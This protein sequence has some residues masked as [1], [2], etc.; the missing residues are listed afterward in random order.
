MNPNN[1]MNPIN[2]NNEPFELDLGPLPVLQRNNPP[3]YFGEV[4]ELLADAPFQEFQLPCD[5]VMPARC[6]RCYWAQ[7]SGT[8]SIDTPFIQA[9]RAAQLAFE[10]EMELPPPPALSR[11]SARPLL[12]EEWRLSPSIPP[13]LARGYTNAYLL[14]ES[15][16][17]DIPEGIEYICLP[18][19][20]DK[21]EDE[22]ED[23]QQDR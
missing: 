6:L 4:E 10:E 12:D 17:F 7:C 13:P 18:I 5:F 19:N 14:D 23:K 15:D 21:D 9:I 11:M 1:Q 8:C 3:V 20:E 16:E 2:P 22:D